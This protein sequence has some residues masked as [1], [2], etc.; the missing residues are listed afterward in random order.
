MTVEELMDW[1]RRSD[2]RLQDIF[3]LWV[4]GKRDDRWVAEKLIAEGHIAALSP[5]ATPSPDAGELER[6]RINDFWWHEAHALHDG[7]HHQ[8][9][10]PMDLC[11]PLWSRAAQEAGEP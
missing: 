7:A 6:L 2:G 5:A 1:L 3:G 11:V 4:Q 10:R 9:H 8:A